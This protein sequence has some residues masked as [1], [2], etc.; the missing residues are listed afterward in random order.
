MRGAASN[1][2]SLQRAEE[3]VKEI[4]ALV[5]SQA[6]LGR[7]L[8]A[9]ETILTVESRELCRL[10]LQAYLDLC[11]DGDVGAEIEMPGAVPILTRKEARSHVLNSVF[12]PVE[13]HRQIY[14][15]PGEKQ[16]CPLDQNLSL[17]AS[18][19]S[20]G[21]QEMAA[22]QIAKQPYADVQ[23]EIRERTGLP[24]AKRSLELLTPTIVRDFD[25]F[26][27]Q[28]SMDAL[29]LASSEILVAEADG[30]GIPMVKKHVDKIPIDDK[31]VEE[32][33]DR[34]KSDSPKR[35]RLKRGEKAGKKKIA[36]AAAV[37]TVA[38]YPRTPEII[39]DK[40]GLQE[41]NAVGPRPRPEHKRVFASLTNSKEE[42]FQAVAEEM[43]RR[44]PERRKIWVF[45]GDGEIAL[46]KLAEKK[47]RPWQPGLIIILDIYHVTEH[48]WAAAYAFH[49]EGSA[50][51][52]AW[53][54]KYLRMILTG[55]TSQAARGMSQS[56]TKRDLSKAKRK[57]VKQ[58][59]RY[60]LKRKRHMRYN[61]YLD[62]GL[63]IGSGAVEGVCRH[64]I[65]ERLECSGMRWTAPGAEAVLK[66]RALHLSG[67]MEEYLEYHRR[68]E[69]QR[70]YESRSWKSRPETPKNQLGQ[71]A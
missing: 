56:A 30:K 33:I 34:Q 41:Q 66:L 68:C 71:V 70:L 14:T 61:E 47:I 38:P 20:Y 69:H 65:K 59:S 3:K 51:A 26:Y 40:H 19:F 4:F 25:G 15:A 1:N 43:L 18:R 12:G 53:V 16:I 31:S 13:S 55:Q 17:P 11:G 58:T 9:V 8:H 67:D 32:K 63:P 37:Y 36:T 54:T 23:M 21:V 10:L 48:L 5:L 28:R 27:A 50:E 52:R 24:I 44:D 42:T 49:A 46:A 39:L 62:M 22:K 57:I 29:T 45:L 60:F 64:L 2:E 7:E 35:R 6:L